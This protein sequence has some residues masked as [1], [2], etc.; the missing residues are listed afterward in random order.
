MNEDKWEQIEEEAD[1]RRERLDA[2]RE[3]SGFMDSAE[4]EKY[5]NDVGQAYAAVWAH[6]SKVD[7]TLHVQQRKGYGGK[8]LDYISW[9][10]CWGFLME[11]YPDFRR[12]FGPNEVHPDGSVSVHCT[13]WIRTNSMVLSQSERLPVTDNSNNAVV[14]PDCDLINTA[15]QR[16]FVK[17]AALFGL[18]HRLY[19]GKEV[20]DRLDKA[21]GKEVP[22]QPE[23]KAAPK[24]EKPKAVP[25]KAQPKPEPAPTLTDEDKTNMVASLINMARATC[26]TPASLIDFWNTNKGDINLLDQKSPEFKHLVEGFTKLKED[27]AIAKPQK[28]DFDEGVDNAK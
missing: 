1:A 20:R 15:Q 27:L 24:P 25:P 3:I 7:V 13:L 23:P 19:L 5:L 12:E 9:A 26:Q 2:A 8:M 14:N 21:E 28:N 17:C 4:G 10:S 11:F 16:C 22:Q 18:G 6:L